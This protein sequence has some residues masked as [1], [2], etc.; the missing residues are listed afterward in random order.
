MDICSYPHRRRIAA[1]LCSR[2]RLVKLSSR[3]TQGQRKVIWHE[4]KGRGPVGADPRVCPLQNSHRGLLL[5]MMGRHGGLPLQEAS[6]YTEARG[7]QRREEAVQGRRRC[8]RTR[9]RSSIPTTSRVLATF[10]GG[11]SWAEPLLK[12][13]HRRIGFGSPPALFRRWGSQVRNSAL[14]DPG[15]IPTAGVR[16][17][18]SPS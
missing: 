7:V 3:A 10:S 5:R 9:R 8:A 16:G 11:G 17:R 15:P 6:K 13:A 1:S 4:G 2:P 14:G 18:A 12:T